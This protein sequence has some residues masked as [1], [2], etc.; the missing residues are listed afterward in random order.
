MLFI[1]ILS[2]GGAKKKQTYCIEKKDASV[3]F[4]F[5]LL[6][7]FAF[8]IEEANKSTNSKVKGREK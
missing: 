5:S 3:I 1:I 6:F 7:F 2:F 4:V 8:T